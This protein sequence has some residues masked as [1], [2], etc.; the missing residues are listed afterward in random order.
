MKW[1]I[2]ALLLIVPL[3]AIQSPPA[4]RQSPQIPYGRYQM[5]FGPHARADMYLLDTETGRIW[6]SQSFS[7][8]KGASSGLEAWVYQE[9]LDTPQDVM[10]FVAM[11]TQND[12]ATEAK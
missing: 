9:R 10:T 2:T 11:H 5:Y 7:N 4:Q 12:S 3:S 1:L 8:I 6:Q